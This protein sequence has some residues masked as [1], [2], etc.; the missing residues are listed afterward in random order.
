MNKMLGLPLDRASVLRLL[1]FVEAERERLVKRH[2]NPKGECETASKALRR[3]LRKI[4][5]KADLVYGEV[6]AED[7]VCKNAWQHCWL[8]IGDTIIDITADQFNDEGDFLPF[9]EIIIDSY[10]NWPQYKRNVPWD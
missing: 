3:K 9:P 4:G 2:P 10:S 7:S 8:E 1:P 6:R 5:V